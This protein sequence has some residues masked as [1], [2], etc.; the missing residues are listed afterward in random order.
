[1]KEGVESVDFQVSRNET[2]KKAIEKANLDPK[3]AE[4]LSKLPKDKL[5]AEG[6]TITEQKAIE[7]PVNQVQSLV[8]EPQMSIN[9]SLNIQK[10]GRNT[11]IGANINMDN[12]EY[13]GTTNSRS[14]DNMVSHMA[15]NKG[16]KEALKKVWNKII[17]ETPEVKIP[18]FGA[19]GQ[20]GWISINEIEK[21]MKEAFEK[22]PQSIGQATGYWTSKGIRFVVPNTYGEAGVETVGVLGGLKSGKWAITKLSEAPKWVQVAL[23]YGG[24]GTDAYS[25]KKGVEAYQTQDYKGAVAGVGLGLAGGGR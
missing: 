16:K 4:Y 24:L 5:K 9:R 12:A 25:I 15:Y 3:Y 21:D 17:K 23:K 8:Y 2:L 10:D 13:V 11:N 20:S 14:Y 18:V 19:S 22:E 1:M 7:L 6:I